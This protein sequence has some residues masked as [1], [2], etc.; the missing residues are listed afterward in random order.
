M[1]VLGHVP[2]TRKQDELGAELGHISRPLGT[3]FSW[4]SSWAWWWYSLWKGSDNSSVPCWIFC[5]HHLF[6]SNTVRHILLASFKVSGKSGSKKLEVVENGRNGQWAVSSFSTWGPA[7]VIVLLFTPTRRQAHPELSS[8]GVRTRECRVAHRSRRLLLGCSAYAAL[9]YC[10]WASF[11]GMDAKWEES[12][13]PSYPAN[14]KGL[15]VL[16]RS[17]HRELK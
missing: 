2:A 1:H 3:A 16:L 5:V 11:S 7:V 13:L 14:V 4:L 9:L 17:R 8:G 10:C 15:L 12:P 6:V